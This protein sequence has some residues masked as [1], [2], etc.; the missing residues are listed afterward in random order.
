MIR[1]RQQLSI[2]DTQDIAVGIFEPGG[3]Y[4][5]AGVNIA[6]SRHP[7]QVVVLELDALGLQLSRYIFHVFSDNPGQAVALFVR[8]YCDR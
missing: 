8:A 2:H 7:R 4:V 3:S 1:R 6:V 5:A